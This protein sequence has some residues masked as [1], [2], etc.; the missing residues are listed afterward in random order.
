M[1]QLQHEFG[2][3]GP[4]VQSMGMLPSFHVCGLACH[5][6]A[7]YK[8]CHGPSP[9]AGVTNKKMDFYEKN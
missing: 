9:V 1:A 6:S 8:L 5:M 3:E 7:M 2:N 4:K